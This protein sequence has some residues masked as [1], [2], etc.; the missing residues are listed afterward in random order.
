M[1]TTQEM[2]DIWENKPVGYLKSMCKRHKG[3]KKYEVTYKPYRISKE[4]FDPISIT[5]LAKNA[6]SASDMV[7]STMSTRAVEKYGDDLNFSISTKELT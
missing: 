6:D 1:L 2:I 4:Y 5:V 7:R 3:D